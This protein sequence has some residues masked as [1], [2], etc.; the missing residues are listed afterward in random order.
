MEFFCGYNPVSHGCENSIRD[1]RDGTFS[2]GEADSSGCVR[3]TD[4]TT[5]GIF[6]DQVDFENRHRR[7]FHVKF[8]LRGTLHFR[9]SWVNIT[10]Y[11]V[12]KDYE[13]TH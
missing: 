3:Y 13:I 10:L 1:K 9:E 7:V 6:A 8:S 11:K 12:P 5:I 2:C 4:L